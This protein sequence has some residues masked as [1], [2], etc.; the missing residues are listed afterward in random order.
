MSYHPQAKEYRAKT[1]SLSAPQSSR[2]VLILLF[3]GLLYWMYS[4]RLLI[5]P[6]SIAEIIGIG[7]QHDTN[8]TS[9]DLEELDGAVRNHAST[10]R[11]MVDFDIDYESLREAFL[12][13]PEP[14]GVFVEMKYTYGGNIE[15]NSSDVNNDS[16]PVSGILPI[17][18]SSGSIRFYRNGSSFRISDFDIS[19]TLTKV[20]IGD[21]STTYYRDQASGEFRASRARRASRPKARLDCLRSTVFSR[22]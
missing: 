6:D 22:S 14:D 11:V 3:G 1:V 2:I 20:I 4:V 5:L 9:I 7:Q 12:L 8:D 13:E 15:V 16:A 17:N 19:G 18:S 10:Q 21:S